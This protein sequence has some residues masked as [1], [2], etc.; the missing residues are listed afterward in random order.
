M[1][2]LDFIKLC[3]LDIRTNTVIEKCGQNLQL[4]Q[5]NRKVSYFMTIGRAK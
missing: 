3:K 2:K 4:L 1:F 5:I